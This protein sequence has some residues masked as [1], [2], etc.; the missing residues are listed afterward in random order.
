MSKKLTLNFTRTRTVVH[1]AS[2]TVDLDDAAAAA[3]LES[4]DHLEA[5]AK[6]TVAPHLIKDWTE[7]HG[8]TFPKIEFEA[9][10]AD[11]EVAK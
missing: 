4:S 5:W 2:I 11:S 6:Y 10:W 8:G 7:Q 3:L 9:V 1:K